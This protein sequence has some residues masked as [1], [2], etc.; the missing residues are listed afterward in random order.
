MLKKKEKEKIKL[1]EKIRYE[2]LEEQPFLFCAPL[3]DRKG[4]ISSK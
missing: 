2:R 1:N 3:A 4:L